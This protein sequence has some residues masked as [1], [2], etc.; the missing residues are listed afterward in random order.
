MILFS[1]NEQEI[2]RETT[3]KGGGEVT[4]RDAKGRGEEGEKEEAGAFEVKAASSSFRF[5]C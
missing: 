3:R 1:I 5:Q 2:K 4:K